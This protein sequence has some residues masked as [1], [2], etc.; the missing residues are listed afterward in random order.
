MQCCNRRGLVSL[1]PLKDGPCPKE[2]RIG[3]VLFVLRNQPLEVGDGLLHI[4]S[5]SQRHRLRQRPR[6]HSDHWPESGALNDC[7]PLPAGRQ[8]DV[9]PIELQ[10]KICKNE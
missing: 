7:Q 2:L 5:S 8:R 10:R 6:H 3:Y 1:T 9:H 4:G